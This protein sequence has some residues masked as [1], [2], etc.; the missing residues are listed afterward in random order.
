MPARFTVQVVDVPDT[1]ASYE[2]NGAALLRRPLHLVHG[3]ECVEPGG[4]K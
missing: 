4:E 1:A 3:E 2:F